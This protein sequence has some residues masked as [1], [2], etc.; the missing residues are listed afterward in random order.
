MF[1]ALFNGLECTLSEIRDNQLIPLRAQLSQSALHKL[2]SLLCCDMH[3]SA[4]G[5]AFSAACTACLLLVSI[6]GS[7]L[8]L[9]MVEK[10]SF[11]KQAAGGT[12][13]D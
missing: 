8:S 6:S 13:L 2:S 3:F 5:L 12:V 9:K 11:S 4:D 7:R 10:H 1:N